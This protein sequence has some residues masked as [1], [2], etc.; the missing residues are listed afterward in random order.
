V[1]GGGQRAAA[2]VT[3]N[4]SND[5]PSWAIIHPYVP[6][7]AGSNPS[8]QMLMSESFDYVPR[9]SAIAKGNGQFEALV[10]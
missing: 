8:L 5:I 6:D 3:L 4:S 10:C 2:A 7:T 1:V 9:K